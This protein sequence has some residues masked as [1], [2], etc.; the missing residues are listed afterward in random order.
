MKSRSRHKTWGGPRDTG[1]IIVTVGLSG[2]A[3]PAD[4]SCKVSDVVR[5]SADVR[6]KEIKKKK[7]GK[8][9]EITMR[10]PTLQMVT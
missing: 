4:N 7:Q 5:A 10:N 9:R 8:G 1:L 2:R 3:A 6:T